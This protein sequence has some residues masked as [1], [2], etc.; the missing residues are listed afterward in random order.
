MRISAIAAI[1]NK[2]GLGK[3]NQLLFKIS[4]DFKRMKALTTG[5]PIIMGRKTF[6]S[7]GRALPNRTNIVITRDI[8]FARGRL[9]RLE[10]VVVV[11]SLEEA[12]E[13]GIMVE[14]RRHSGEPDSSGDSRIRSWT[15]QD[16]VHREAMMLKDEGE[17]FIFGGAQ[18][19]E[20]SLPMVDRLYLTVVKG[21]YGADA[22]FPDYSMF[23][24]VIN[25]EDHESEG[26]HYTFLDLER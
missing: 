6:E 8:S 26:Y 5:H 2:R 13:K 7:I 1:D 18:I 9:A 10:G 19:F 17:I 4:E 15:S 21:D 25:K 20:Q 16:D 23:K 14:N 11:Y 12:L 22:F 3:N 24:T